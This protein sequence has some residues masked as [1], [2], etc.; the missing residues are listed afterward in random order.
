MIRIYRF[1]Y[2]NIKRKS[3]A[4]PYKHMEL[5]KENQM[6]NSIEWGKSWNP[7]KGLCPHNSICHYC[8]MA[9][10][11]KRFKMNPELRLDEK[12]LSHVPKGDRIFVCSNLDLFADAI[13]YE[14][15]YKVLHRVYN[16]ERSWTV[17]DLSRFKLQYMFLT[18]NP[19][20]YK[21]FYLGKHEW[22]GT[23]WD[24]LAFTRDNI[25]ILA[26]YGAINRFVSF[27]PLLSSPEGQNIK[28]FNWI[29]IG[30]DSRKGQAKPPQAWADYLIAQARE[31]GIPVFVK[32]N[33]GYPEI[34]QE[35][36]K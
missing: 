24:G 5:R 18:K 22:A 13:S 21:P 3:E 7:V 14:W 15:I 6:G 27:E 34:I 19:K 33:Y 4:I 9:G 25:A 11:H 31:Q 10:F 2:A 30:A 1:D 8:Y 16:A 12:A 29:I 35:F 28:R 26:E 20:R 23:T 36:P 17:R 32:K